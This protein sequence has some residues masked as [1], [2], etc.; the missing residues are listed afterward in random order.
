MNSKFYLRSFYL[1]TLIVFVS[2]CASYYG[3]K[4]E[5]GKLRVKEKY[6]TLKNISKQGLNKVLGTKAWYRS[7]YYFINNDFTFTDQKDNNYKN[8]ETILWFFDSGHVLR[9]LSYD[10]IGES[11]TKKII[12]SKKLNFGTQGFYT[13]GSHEFELEFF[14]KQNVSF[15]GSMDRYFYNAQLKGNT[16]H[17]IRQ[18]QNNRFV[19]YIY[20]KIKMPNELKNIKADW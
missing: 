12:N 5:S 1:I 9:C 8:N 6:W 20:K 7:E 17:L 15:F 10:I 18:N 13:L 14:Q 2:S 3:V 4:D 16:L 19:H 11:N